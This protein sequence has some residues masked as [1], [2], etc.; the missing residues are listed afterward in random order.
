MNIIILGPQGCGKGTQAELLS[1]KLNI[2]TIS[3]GQVLRDEAE[4][5]TPMGRKI[6]SLIDKGNLA[7]NKW[8]LKLLLK[9]I[10]KKDCG[11]GFI[12]DGY[13]RNKAQLE[14]MKKAIK[15]NVVF[16]IN[17]SE[18]ESIKRLSTRRQCEKCNTIYNIITKKPKMPGRCDK[19]GSKIVQRDDDKPAAIKK[20]LK[21]YKNETKLVFDYFSKK[22][23]LV[24]INGEQK[25][26]K[27]H[28]DILKELEKIHG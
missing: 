22:K 16:R 27:V 10:K 9:R 4:K 15:I 5:N 14:D 11:N 25:I 12:L 18:K 24:N 19:C 28:E 23:M 20:R 1:K 21:I 6:K 13:P 26:E 2:P 3:A 7:P 17:I 8:T